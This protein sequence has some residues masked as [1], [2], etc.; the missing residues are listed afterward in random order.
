[1]KPSTHGAALITIARAGAPDLTESTVGAGTHVRLV[2]ERNEKDLDMTAFARRAAL[3]L[4]VLGATAAP[5]HAGEVDASVMRYDNAGAYT[6]QFYI[7]YKLEDGTTCKVKPDSTVSKVVKP[8]G[9]TK[10][11]LSDK[12]TV[13]DGGRACL[14]ETFNIPLGGQVWGFVD[15]SEGEG[16]TCKK[17]K[18]VMYRTTGSLIKYKTKG[19]TLNNNRCQVTSW[20]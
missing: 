16:K 9:W 2:C 20:P 7:K 19:T 13:K 8:G 1:M 17:D 3:L 15:I 5:I 12:M 4:A 10:Y 6:A 11:D 18:R 14:D